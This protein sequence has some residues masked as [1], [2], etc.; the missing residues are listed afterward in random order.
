MNGEAA[1][2]PMVDHPARRPDMLLVFFIW[3]AAVALLVAFVF[4]CRSY[5]KAV[6]GP[7]WMS[8]LAVFGL[9]LLQVLVIIPALR[10]RSDF[11]P[12]GALVLLP[13]LLVEIL[14]WFAFTYREICKSLL[15]FAAL[16]G[17]GSALVL[18]AVVFAVTG[19]IMGV[20]DGMGKQLK[21]LLRDQSFLVVCFFLTVFTFI[22]LFLS[23]SLALH[24]Q[25]L[26]LN[27]RTFALHAEDLEPVAE[28]GNVDPSAMESRKEPPRPFRI[29]FT[30][31]SVTVEARDGV[32]DEELAVLEDPDERRKALNARHL[33]SL[34]A[35]IIEQAEKDHVR[36][37]LGGYS[38]DLPVN[39][40]SGSY[41]SNF[42]LSQARINQV[43][44]ALISRLETYPQREW[45]RNVEWLVLPSATGQ[46]FLDGGGETQP[47][48]RLV[49]QVALLPSD[50]D[51]FSHVARAEGRDLTLLDYIY[52]GVYTITTTGYGDIKPVSAF[53][54]FITIVANFFEIFLIVVFFNVLLSLLREE[55]GPPMAGGVAAAA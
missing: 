46:G 7:E 21:I 29:L 38:N 41:K 14:L 48:T 5:A 9:P 8:V 3:G 16:F 30:K 4:A 26:R 25:D 53:S 28:N 10:K 34:T 15:G 39:P 27:Q 35:A 50:G 32:S 31:G 24:D 1:N 40:T 6:P 47:E 44:T 49:V 37:V 17:L 18:G 12:L 43:M 23:L 45:R 33:G 13:S 19:L 22:T 55:H 51:R 20:G 42:E 52:F 36:V 11:G 2:P 54:K